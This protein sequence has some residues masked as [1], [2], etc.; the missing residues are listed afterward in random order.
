MA[1][2]LYS[3]MQS[4]R[5]SLKIDTFQ[6]AITSE[7]MILILETSTRPFSCLAKVIIIENLSKR[8]L[9]ML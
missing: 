9:H 3:V 2:S 8:V 1:V 7:L 4:D 6:D 5:N